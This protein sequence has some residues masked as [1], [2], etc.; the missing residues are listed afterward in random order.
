[1][2]LKKAGVEYAPSQRLVSPLM[3]PT[4]PA[5][6]SVDDLVG[7]GAEAAEVVAIEQV[8]RSVLVRGD[9]QGER[10][11]CLV[12]QETI[13]LSRDP[14]PGSRG[15]SGWRESSSRP[16]GPFA[17]LENFRTLSPYSTPPVSALNLPLAVAT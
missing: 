7:V 1:M 5:G 12:G 3:T 17:A 11:P 16:L 4:E 2:L 14:G 15:G 8:D 9:E 10:S 6:V 13:P